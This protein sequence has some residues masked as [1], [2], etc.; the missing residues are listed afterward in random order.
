MEN[1]TTEEVQSYRIVILLMVILA[2]V[3]IYLVQNSPAVLIPLFLK[4]FHITHTQAGLLVG[5]VFIAYGVMSIP[6]GIVIDKIGSNLE[7][8]HQQVAFGQCSHQ[9]QRNRGFT[10]AAVRTGYDDAFDDN[11]P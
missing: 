7:R 1:T 5:A 11:P 6:G 4:E 10:A 2:Q 3:A 8:C 9:S